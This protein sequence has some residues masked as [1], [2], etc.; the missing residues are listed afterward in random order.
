MNPSQQ[1]AKMKNEIKLTEKQNEILNS[2]VLTRE[3][4]GETLKVVDIFGAHEHR[5]MK[6]LMDKGLVSIGSIQPYNES[7]VFATRKGQ[8]IGIGENL[9]LTYEERT[10]QEITLSNNDRFHLMEALKNYEPRF[11]Y[12]WEKR[13][14]KLQNLLAV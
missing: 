9:S 7:Y 3:S 2:P 6:T 12:D 4:R 8:A 10:E 5:S 1:K 13:L 11:A 14:T